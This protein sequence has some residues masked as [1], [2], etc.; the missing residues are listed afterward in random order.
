MYEIGKLLKY[1]N[2]ANLYLQ[3][4]ATCIAKVINYFNINTCYSRKTIIN[5]SF[6]VKISIKDIGSF[7]CYIHLYKPV[8]LN[9]KS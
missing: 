8:T 5:C 4:Y 1:L 2:S 9:H 6:S 7:M 3:K